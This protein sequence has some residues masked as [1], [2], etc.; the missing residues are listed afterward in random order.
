MTKNLSLVNTRFWILYKKFVYQ[1]FLKTPVELLIGPLFHK[2]GLVHYCHSHYFHLILV[3]PQS[4]LTTTR[5]LIYRT[6]LNCFQLHCT[7][8]SLIILR[9]LI[10]LNFVLL[11]G[12]V[13]KLC[14]LNVLSFTFLLFIVFNGNTT[15]HINGANGTGMPWQIM[16]FCTHLRIVQWYFSSFKSQHSSRTWHNAFV[17]P[18]LV[19]HT[20]LKPNC[21]VCPT[22]RTCRPSL[23][24]FHLVHKHILCTTPY[25]IWNVSV[26]ECL[27]RNL[28]FG[29]S[30]NLCL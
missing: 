28:F 15:I 2:S 20:I 29:R 24:S 30:V 12:Y 11:S 4:N 21:D 5:W 26:P 27:S 8:V 23:C 1:L 17:S 16:E 10:K 22:S 18:F 13:C 25:M 14:Q 6:N 3:V 9:I 19:K 7:H